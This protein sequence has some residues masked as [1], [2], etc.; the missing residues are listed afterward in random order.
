ML[1]TRMI[2]LWQEKLLIGKKVSKENLIKVYKLL[3]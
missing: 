3:T 1:F 2:P